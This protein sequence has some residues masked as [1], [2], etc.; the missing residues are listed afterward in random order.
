MTPIVQAQ[1]TAYSE[2]FES[3]DPN[4]ID[5]LSNAGWLVFG[6]VSDGSGN[7][8]YGYGPFPAPNGGSGVENGFSRLVTGQGGPDQGDVSLNTFND[9]Q[10]ADHN[11]PDRIIEANIYREQFIGAV[12]LGTTWRFGFECKASSD[13]G[14]EPPSTTMAF[15]KVLDSVGGSYE[16]LAFETFVTT[17]IPDTWGGGFVDITINPAWFGQLLQIGFLNT[18]QQ[19]SPTGI[20]YDNLGFDVVTANAFVAPSSFNVFRGILVSGTLADVAQSD[21]MYMTFNPGFT[22]NSSEAPVWVEFQ[23]N[24]GTGGGDFDLTVES[25][26]GTPGLTYTVEMWNFNN[27]RYDVVGVTGES[28]NV[29]SVETYPIDP[30]N[31]VSGSGEVETRIGWRKTGF[32]INYPWVPKLDQIG[33]AP[34]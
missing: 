4:D 30:V 8:L 3:L 14:P 32:T 31:Q 18:S 2:D 7:Y 16:L 28:F 9:Y 27:N 33:W 25:Q 13:F 1:L 5:A 6:N 23:G 26:A 15:I 24:V 17:D 19:F 21:N 22:V 20:I 29:D 12:D 11:N 10:N 34:Q